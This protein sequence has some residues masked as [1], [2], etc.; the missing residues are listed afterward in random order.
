V[1]EHW[2]KAVEAAKHRGFVLGVHAAPSEMDQVLRAALP[3][4]VEDV[5][6]DVER[7]IQWRSEYV[8]HH[9]VEMALVSRHS[10]RAY[11]LTAAALL[12]KEA[13]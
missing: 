6:T 1:S 2:D 11:F 3:H 7:E 4:L 9:A 8:G 5:L 12:A 13:P 10:L